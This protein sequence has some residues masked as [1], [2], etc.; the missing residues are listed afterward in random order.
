MT[1]NINFPDELI[2]ALEAVLFVSGEP[3]KKSALAAILKIDENLVDALAEKLDGLLKGRESGL[4]LITAPEGFQMV[5]SEKYCETI[6]SFLKSGIRE[7]LSSAA[8]ETLAIVAYRGPISRAKIEAIRGVNCS[9]SLRLLSI[10]GLIDRKASENDSRVFLYN[11]NADFLRHLGV[12][13]IEDLP[14]YEK[15]RQHEGMLQ[16]E[17]TAE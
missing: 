16:L 2:G 9:F 12:S 11:V 17:K 1:E 3:I 15:F 13:K 5:T 6:E 8:A 10:R 4:R 7:Q 14:E